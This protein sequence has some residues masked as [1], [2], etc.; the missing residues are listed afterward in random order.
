MAV[1]K[2]GTDDGEKD[3]NVIAE[4]LEVHAEVPSDRVIFASARR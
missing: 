1:M 4:A 3:A 2:P